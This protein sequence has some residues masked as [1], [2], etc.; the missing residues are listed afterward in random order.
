MARG[1]SGPKLE[2]LSQSP[3]GPEKNRNKPLSS[4]RKSGGSA[5]GA[6]PDRFAKPQG[7]RSITPRRVI[8]KTASGERPAKPSSVERAK[9]PNPAEL[10]EAIRDMQSQIEAKIVE[11]R[12][13]VKQLEVLLERVQDEKVEG[14][15]P[16]TVE[17]LKSMNEVRKEASSVPEPER[18]A[19][20]ALAMQKMGLKK[21]QTETATKVESLIRSAQ[22]ELEEKGLPLPQQVATF[23]GE[24]PIREIGAIIFGGGT[25]ASIGIME[26]GTIASL[27]LMV[28]GELWG[29]HYPFLSLE[30]VASTGI[31]TALVAPLIEAGAGTLVGDPIRRG[32]NPL[33]T[34][35]RLGQRGP[36]VVVA[37]L[38]VTSLSAVVQPHTF[39]TMLANVAE[40]GSVA[41]KATQGKQ[42]IEGQINN[43]APVAQGLVEKTDA[44]MRETI[45]TEILGK[46]V[47]G[48][49]GSGKEGIGPG[50]AFKIGFLLQKWDAATARAYGLDEIK[51]GAIPESQQEAFNR[52][53]AARGEKFEGALSEA[54]GTLYA[55]FE[56]DVADEKVQIV[57]R[58]KELGA[59]AEEV[60][61]WVRNP[62]A[63]KAAFTVGYVPPGQEVVDRRIQEALKPVVALQ[64]RYAKFVTEVNELLGGAS[65]TLTLAAQEAGRQE[66]A[67]EIEAEAMEFDTSA[68][69]IEVG[70]SISL[71]E[72]G[73]AYEIGAK[74][75]LG[76]DEVPY[77]VLYGVLIASLTLTA[78]FGAKAG[79]AALG[80]RR[81]RLLR[82]RAE[83]QRVYTVDNEA[84]YLA[85]FSELLSRKLSRLFAEDGGLLGDPVMKEQLK[86]F[87]DKQW[88]SL[89][90]EMV[91]LAI[92]DVIAD[93]PEV[94]ATGKQN[95]VEGLFE[96]W[97]EG[98]KHLVNRANPYEV[99][100]QNAVSQLL[101]DH[102]ALAEK[103]TERLF[104]GYSK[105]ERFIEKKRESGKRLDGREVREFDTMYYSLI[106]D[107]LE[108]RLRVEE[109]RLAWCR[110]AFRKFAKTNALAELG[111]EVLEELDEPP[112]DLKRGLT[113]AETGLSAQKLAGS[114]KRRATIKTLS[115]RMQDAQTAI[116]EVRGIAADLNKSA[117]QK[118]VLLKTTEEGETYRRIDS[119]LQRLDEVDP[120]EEVADEKLAS[121]TPKGNLEIAETQ[122]ALEEISERMGV[123]SASDASEDYAIREARIA[124]Q[125]NTLARVA[126][127]RW[128]WEKIR[129]GQGTNLYADSLGG[130]RYQ[131]VAEF[132]V[133]EEDDKNPAPFYGVEFKIIHKETG[134]PVVR[135]HYSM[136]RTFSE[137]EEEKTIEGFYEKELRTLGMANVA[138]VYSDRVTRA[139]D[140][141]REKYGV[142]PTANPIDL[143]SSKALEN[144][145]L[146]FERVLPNQAGNSYFRSLEMNHRSLKERLPTLKQE[147]DDTGESSEEAPAKRQLAQN[148]KSLADTAE[149]FVVPAIAPRMSREQLTAIASELGSLRARAVF[150]PEKG[151][152]TIT[153]QGFAGF[154]RKTA[155]LPINDFRSRYENTGESMKRTLDALFPKR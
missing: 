44:A 4:I 101:R 50:A 53:V 23:R 82:E 61:F 105:L 121:L 64:E 6:S 48:R 41:E 110:S 132:K 146:Y 87:A 76:N 52:G 20:F 99:T 112:V 144:L 43:L 94:K 85:Q 151:T 122:R 139:L 40:S 107:H 97:K 155:E 104:P 103:L 26:G 31:I 73:M 45:A 54:V 7:P 58:F 28:Q 98:A 13:A 117:M 62:T 15:S 19:W 134:T 95:P 147:Y 102:P 133:I 90:P 2:A 69:N 30:H 135:F 18:E 74:E 120:F 106:T 84:G 93:L 149:S 24:R 143:S 33:S 142:R 150:D 42:S 65:A 125:F 116:E 57:E 32:E 137:G 25:K 124:G 9:D 59:T 127:A 141:A 152:M 36:L 71:K 91:R 154:G 131:Q 145:A 128:S 63:A 5:P 138:T 27:A 89:T 83:E 72:L 46:Q 11:L 47:A 8:E 55:S 81:N 29:T 115:S 34:L 88:I 129:T 109:S 77:R 12:P 22:L 78:L 17:M 38:G 10:V 66:G 130:G 37:A 114:A 1:S 148:F 126:S 80:R 119:L 51:Y 96:T 21:S 14:L 60:D 35:Q 79:F 16:E 56:A 140:T 67:I 86:G 68:L 3:S 49:G 111:L 92:L 123:V 118:Q 39:A 113:F 153:K 75:Y 108:E 100:A 70:S 136:A